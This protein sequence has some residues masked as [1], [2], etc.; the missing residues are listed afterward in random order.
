MQENGITI[1]GNAKNFNAHLLNNKCS[2]NKSYI[3]YALRHVVHVGCIEEKSL[4]DT[5]IT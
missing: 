2:N 1:K 5:I 3:M 4:N